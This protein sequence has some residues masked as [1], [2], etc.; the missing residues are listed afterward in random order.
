[1]LQF[2]NILYIRVFQK[3]RTNRIR[4]PTHPHTHIHI[5][6]HKFLLQNWLIQMW[7]PSSKPVGQTGRLEILVQ[8]NDVFLGSKFQRAVGQKL[9]Q[10]FYIAV[11]RICS[12]WGKLT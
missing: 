12:I 1:M 5:H 2:P 4:T 7:G 10:V 3:N 11:L 8:I 6:I 9:I